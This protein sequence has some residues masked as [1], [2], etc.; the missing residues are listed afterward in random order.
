LYLETQNPRTLGPA[1]GPKRL[2]SRPRTQEHWVLTPDP[3]ELGSDTK[4]KANW[5][6]VWST[7]ENYNKNNNIDTTNNN[8]FYINTFNYN[9]NNNI[10][11][12]N[13]NIFNI[14]TINFNE[15]NNI[16][17]TNNTIFSI[18]IKIIIFIIQTILFLK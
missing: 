15:S 17:N 7:Q 1:A 11:K 4:P 6:C 14:N 3:I 9:K 5:F 2:G 16:Y 8:I 18:I 13:D 12:I 10:Y